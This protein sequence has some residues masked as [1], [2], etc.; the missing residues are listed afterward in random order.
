MK[1]KLRQLPALYLRGSLVNE[2]IRHLTPTQLQEIE[3]LTSEISQDPSLQSHRRE[4]TKQLRQTI[5]GDYDDPVAADIE[6][7]IAIWRGLAELLHH[8]KY[9]FICGE[10]RSSSYIMNNGKRKQF[11]RRLPFCRECGIVI[12][13]NPGDH[14]LEKDSKIDYKALQKLIQSNT[15]LT[16]PTTKSPILA[17]LEQKK[18][19]KLE[20]SILDDPNQK[21]KFFGEFIWG[22]FKQHISENKI[23]QHKQSYKVLSMSD[24]AAIEDISTI[25]KK[26][27]VDYIENNGQFQATTLA[28]SPEFSIELLQ[29]K[30]KYNGSI[31]LICEDNKIEVKS[32]KQEVV[33]AV[34]TESRPITTI[35]RFENNQDDTDIVNTLK[36]N[37]QDGS[38]AEIEHND[39][40]FTI[41]KKLSTKESRAVFDMLTGFDEEFSHTRPKINQMAKI[42]EVSTKQIGHYMTEIKIQMVAHGLCPA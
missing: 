12:I 4:F 9:S 35:S 41:R 21:R 42:L 1:K 7:Y 38:I 31:S 14:N 6:F 8:G 30:A 3:Q 11:D 39:R 2:T 13:D 16:P 5:G 27:K 25:L 10:C 22:Y 32:L 19:D 15:N 20:R 26:Y 28:T 37:N 34:F 23:K 40:L 33:E 29:V 36:D 17:K 18:Y 24:K